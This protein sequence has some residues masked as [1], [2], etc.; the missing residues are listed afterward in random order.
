MVVGKALQA[1][2]I[3]NADAQL[4][5]INVGHF[6]TMFPAM[7]AN[8][9]PPVIAATWFPMNELTT[10]TTIVSLAAF[11]G[12]GAAFIMGPAL[13]PQVPVNDTLSVKLNISQE[14]LKQDIMVRWFA[15]YM[16]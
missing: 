8:G 11:A 10:A 1:L 2:P 12:V 3:A 7:I 13:V 6:I 9:A 14:H 4:V 5:M 15:V 16:D